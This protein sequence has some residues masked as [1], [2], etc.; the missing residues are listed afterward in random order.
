M[1]GAEVDA[2]IRLSMELAQGLKINGTPTFV[3]G[4]FV[5]PG[6]IPYEQLADAVANERNKEK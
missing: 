5:G 6:L 3:V 4:D 2:H 1:E